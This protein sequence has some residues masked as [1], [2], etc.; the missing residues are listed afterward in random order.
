MPVSLMKRLMV[1]MYDLLLLCAVLFAAGV[2][3]AGVT[4]FVLNDGNAITE[5]HPYFQLYQVYLLI[6]LLIVS[7]IFYGWFWTNG[8]QTLGMKTWKLRLTRLDGNAISWKQA[9][10]RFLTAILSWACFGIGFLCI[11]FTADKRAW[12]DILSQTI[13]VQVEIKKYAHL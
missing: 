4:T 7:F 12:H 9:G 8:G 13:I 2:V 3:I 1:I 10:I 6:S 11:L 5:D